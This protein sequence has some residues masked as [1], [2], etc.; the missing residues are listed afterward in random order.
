MSSPYRRTFRG[1]RRF[2]TPTDSVAVAARS[3]V[4]PEKFRAITRTVLL[5]QAKAASWMNRGDLIEDG[6]SIRAANSIRVRQSVPCGGGATGFEPSLGC[7]P[8]RGV[9]PCNTLSRR[10]EADGGSKTDRAAMHPAVTARSHK[11]LAPAS[12]KLDLR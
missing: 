8:E 11:P 2:T 12:R 7:T 10:P 4:A 5:V 6:V 3:N 9:D 1:A